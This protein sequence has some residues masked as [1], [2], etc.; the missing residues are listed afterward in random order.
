MPRGQPDAEENESDRHWFGHAGGVV[1]DSGRRQ[2]RE[3]GGGNRH[4][5]TP[6]TMA[7]KEDQDHT[8][9]AE[10]NAQQTRQNDVGRSR[11][12]EKKVHQHRME[13]APEVFPTAHVP[14]PRSV[15][16][17]DLFGQIRDLPVVISVGETV[18]SVLGVGEHKEIDQAR[19]HCGDC[20][21]GYPGPRGTRGQLGRRLASRSCVPFSRF[22]PIE[23]VLVGEDL[24]QEP[25][26]VAASAA[27]SS[28]ERATSTMHRSRMS[29]CFS[30]SKRRAHS[31]ARSPI[32][33]LAT[34]SSS[35]WAT[36][37]ANSPTSSGSAR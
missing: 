24:R 36:S 28:C 5:K 2:G 30:Q 32:A 34:G 21:A 22:L 18:P 33:W 27:T 20:N 10:R 13:Q 8:C 31:K 6:I 3:R 19:Y 11:D 9:R 17:S 4:P 7:E 29:R 12:E 37:R 15:G 25:Q 14:E 16:E 23:L 35:N 26:A 1:E